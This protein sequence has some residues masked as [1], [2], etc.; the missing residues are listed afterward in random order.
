[1]RIKFGQ[2]F[3]ELLLPSAVRWEG[4]GG[5]RS[6][7]QA[8]DQVRAL[9][10]YPHSGN[11]CDMPSLSFPTGV[12][13]LLQDGAVYDPLPVAG[14]QEPAADPAGLAGVR[15]GHYRRAGWAGEVMP[16]QLAWG[17]LQAGGVSGCLPWDCPIRAPS[18]LDLRGASGCHPS[19]CDFQRHGE[20]CVWDPSICAWCPPWLWLVA[21]QESPPCSCYESRPPVPAW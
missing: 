14:D 11:R 15:L 18:L 3:Q 10:E 2:T 7:E 17:S 19:L 9:L 21:S 13:E 20:L 6:R 1:M 8:E 16:R 12:R 5:G 4:G